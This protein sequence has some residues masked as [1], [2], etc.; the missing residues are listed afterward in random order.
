METASFFCFL[1]FFKVIM[2]VWL[3]CIEKKKTVENLA[4]YEMICVVIPESVPMRTAY[5]KHLLISACLVLCSQ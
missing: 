4:D 2:S 5:L 1:L 3:S